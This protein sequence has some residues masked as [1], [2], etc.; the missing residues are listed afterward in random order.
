MFYEEKIIDG[1]LMC[2]HDPS[3][4]WMKCS[5]ERMNEK[6]YEL[7]RSINLSVTEEE[8]KEPELTEA[9][10]KDY[11]SDLFSNFFYYSR[12]EDDTFT[13]EMAE[14]FS[15]YI[16]KENFLKLV[17]SEVSNIWID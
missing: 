13:M 16:S 4:E 5:V 9:K 1:L 15:R 8:N 2:R 7:Q 3:A 10:I 12:K 11:V 6:V 14:N 17:E